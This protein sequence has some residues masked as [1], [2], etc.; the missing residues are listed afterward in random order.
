[1]SVK[2]TV[3]IPTH[4]HGRTLNY[5]IKSVLNQTVKDFE[6]FVVG[7]GISEDGRQVAKSFIQKDSRIKLFDNPKGPRHGEVWRH[8]ALK[9]AKGRIICYL[10]DDDLWMPNHLEEMLAISKSA[11]FFHTLPVSILANDKIQVMPIDVSLYGYQMYIREGYKKKMFGFGLSFAGHT[12]LLYEKLPYGWRTTPENIFTDIYMYRQ[13]LEQSG[14]RSGSLFIP[15]VINLESKS[16]KL[17]SNQ[18][19]V[20]EIIK[21]S[22]LIEN[23]EERNKFCTMV[24]ELGL[25]KYAEEKLGVMYTSEGVKQKINRRLKR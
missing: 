20:D 11:D 18:S 7:D 23:E 22:L 1:M 5:S 13:I 25:G 3:L 14:C 4:D 8:E 16:R 12:R 10:C 24:Y 15:T 6:L 17:W 2:V 21:W 19:R 9:Q